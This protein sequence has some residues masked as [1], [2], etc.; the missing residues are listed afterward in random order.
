[1][2]YHLFQNKIKHITLFVAVLVWGC[3]EEKPKEQ[4]LAEETVITVR[5]DS[6]KTTSR[7]ELIFLPTHYI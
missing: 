4:Q 5:L 3:G 6:V 7:S 2:N 1:M